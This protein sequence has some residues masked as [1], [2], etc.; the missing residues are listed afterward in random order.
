MPAL[1]TRAD[2]ISRQKLLIVTVK[3]AYLEGEGDRV[4]VNTRLEHRLCPRTHRIADPDACLG[5]NLAAHGLCTWPSCP[6]ASG[7]L[8]NKTHDCLMRRSL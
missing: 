1:L 6:R 5:E 2:P 7:C 3:S 4:T 8:P